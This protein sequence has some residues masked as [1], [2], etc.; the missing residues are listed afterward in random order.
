MVDSG[1]NPLAVA[2]KFRDRLYGI[3]I[4][5]FVFDRSGRPEDIVVGTDN[6]DLDGLA[7]FLTATS[8]DGYLT[9]EYEGDVNDPIPATKQCVKAVQESFA[10]IG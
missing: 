10:K 7:S 9:L 5:D 2:E 4:K 3:H 1:E 8:Y 6:L